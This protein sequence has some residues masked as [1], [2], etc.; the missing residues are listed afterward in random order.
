MPAIPLPTG[1]TSVTDFPR[2]RETLVNLFNV[3]SGLMRTPGIEAVDTTEIAS[4]AITAPKIDGS[5]VAGTHIADEAIDSIHLAGS[6]VDGT[7]V[8]DGVIDSIHLVGSLVDGT[9]VADGAANG[10]ADFL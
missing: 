5:A 8:A 9:H 10:P 7:H 4:E 6:S 2:L 3:G 1:F